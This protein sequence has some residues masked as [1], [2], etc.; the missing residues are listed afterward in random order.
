MAALLSSALVLQ[1]IEFWYQYAEP[2]KLN[3]PKYI[4]E[5]EGIVWLRVVGR[6]KHVGLKL[7]RRVY[8]G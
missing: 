5:V 1:N 6:I 4:V 8:E 7:G 2:M 3:I